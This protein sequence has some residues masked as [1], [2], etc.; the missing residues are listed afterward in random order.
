[1]VCGCEMYG[2]QFCGFE[3]ELAGRCWSCERIETEEDCAKSGAFKF[4]NE[5]V[6]GLADC[7][8]RCVNAKET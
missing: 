7:I 6:L 5:S 4:G 3:K 1:M 2:G 8:E